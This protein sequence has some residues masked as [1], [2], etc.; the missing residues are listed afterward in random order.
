MISMARRRLWSFILPGLAAT[1]MG[2]PAPHASAIRGSAQSGD[3][4]RV[5]SAELIA[6]GVRDTVYIRRVRMFEELAATIPTDS[7]ARVMTAA[8]NAPVEQA[9]NFE[10]A[11]LCQQFRMLWQYGAIATK[12]ALLRMDDSL[13][14]VPGRRQRWVEVKDHFPVISG[15]DDARCDVSNLPHAA[16]SLN[17][18]PYSSAPP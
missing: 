4:D 13:F 11:V 14:A 9:P 10:Q 17:N 7:L 3:P 15:L 12:R 2:C 18:Q 5:T 1:L 8:M 16:D 6:A